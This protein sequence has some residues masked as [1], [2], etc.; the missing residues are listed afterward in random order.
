MQLPKFTFVSKVFC[1]RM[2]GIGSLSRFPPLKL[3]IKDWPSPHYRHAYRGEKNL[4]HRDTPII[5]PNCDEVMFGARTD[6]P[7]PVC[8]L[9]DRCE[10][11][12]FLWIEKNLSAFEWSHYQLCGVS[13]FACRLSMKLMQSETDLNPL[14]FA[15]VKLLFA[16]IVKVVNSTYVCVNWNSSLFLPCENVVQ[17][18]S[19]WSTNT[20]VLSIMVRKTAG[21]KSH[22]FIL[23][24]L[25][26][27]RE[28]EYRSLIS[29]KNL[30]V[31]SIFSSTNS[32]IQG[33]WNSESHEHTLYPFHLPNPHQ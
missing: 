28:Q 30:V 3:T 16:Q 14:T 7:N 31:Q 24:D 12:A 11:N 2:D 10:F 25:D 27:C 13:A 17:Y 8:G 23:S 1:L 26:W 32:E 20:Y 22:V 33:I 6:T 9:A 15:P 4:K 21:I 29:S 5:T 19:V 18:L